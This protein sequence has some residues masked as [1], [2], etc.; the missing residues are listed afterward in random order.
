MRTASDL[1]TPNPKMVASGES[2]QD[3]IVLFLSQGITSS[4]VVNP[5]GEI[6]G[7][8]TELSLVKAY[9]LHRAKLSRSDKIGHH[10]D[11]LEP[12]AYVNQHSALGDVL[13]EMISSP[14]HRLLVKD[15]R[16]KVVGILSP[17]DLMRAMLGELNPSQNIREKLAETETQLKNSLHL[18]ET[19]EKRL[20]VY[21]QAFHETPYMMHA[22]DTKGIIIMANKREHEFLGYAD[23]ELVGKS[24][25]EIYAPAMHGEAER[26]LRRVM[27]VG[28]HY[29]TY[30]TLVR[31]DG[32]LLRCDIASSALHNAKGEF[33][34]TISVL[35]PVDSDELLRVLNGIV[36]DKSG[37]L[38]R[39]AY[40]K[41]TPEEKN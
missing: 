39:Y 36:D 23:G 21:R 18:V 37:P 29:I 31:K 7:V 20:E 27:E 33:Q 28:Y 15:N 10:L 16:D 34:S 35:R 14:S 13:K 25:F 40:K 1:M 5:L 12:V 9:M 32:S 30:T 22:V 6:L 2:L 26:G 4:P 19:L 11:L 8:L 41:D 3:T 24:I 38:A 17:K